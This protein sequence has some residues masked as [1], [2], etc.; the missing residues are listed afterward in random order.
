MC[1]AHIPLW[2]VWTK[3]FPFSI[4]VLHT[5]KCSTNCITHIALSLSVHGLIYHRLH[6]CHYQP[7]P[8]SVASKTLKATTEASP[9]TLPPSPRPLLALSPGYFLQLAAGTFFP[10]LPPG[11]EASFHSIVGLT[12]YLLNKGWS[13]FTWKLSSGSYL[14]NKTENFIPL[15]PTGWPAACFAHSS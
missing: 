5:Y 13:L 15:I 2:H 1:I 6:W 14:G 8:T 7:P 12:K 3:S 11:P 10:S 9:Q 4:P